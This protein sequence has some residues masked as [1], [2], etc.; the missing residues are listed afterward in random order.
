[1]GDDALKWLV[2]YM[3][4]D[5]PNGENDPCAVDC[6]RLILYATR[7]KQARTAR[8]LDA[9]RHPIRDAVGPDGIVKTANVHVGALDACGTPC[10]TLDRLAKEAHVNLAVD[11][12]GLLPQE[13]AAINPHRLLNVR[14]GP[15]S[16]RGAVNRLFQSAGGNCEFTYAEIDNV[17]LATQPEAARIR[18]IRSYDV[19]D[20]VTDFIAYEQSH[21]IRSKGIAPRNPADYADQSMSELRDLV[22]CSVTPKTWFN[23]GGS[24]GMAVPGN[25]LLFVVGDADQQWQVSRALAAFRLV[26]RSGPVGRPAAPRCLQ[27]DQDVFEK[28]VSVVPEL[29]LDDVPIE[30][31]LDMLGRIA[32]LSVEVDPSLQDVVRQPLRRITLRRQNIPFHVALQG[33]LQ[34]ASAGTPLVYGIR[35]GVILVTASGHQE[36]LTRGYRVRDL[37]ERWI[38]GHPF[39]KSVPDY[40]GHDMRQLGASFSPENTIDEPTELL[41]QILQKGVDELSWKIAGGGKISEI[42]GILIITQSPENHIKIEA[43]LDALRHNEAGEAS[44]L[45][46]RA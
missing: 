22:E 38:R 14:H 15:M 42:A 7:E 31:A 3:L 28:L 20:L 9:L 26:E 37:V 41:K 11:W 32:G 35:D 8:A 45:F 19:H 21:Q 44:D 34:Q 36:G 43:L 39:G 29:S 30:T 40:F 24:F 27:P 33:V 25:G 16:L 1:M 18:L 46:S 12:S 13:Q 4:R 2:V 10:D 17:L 5:G 6:G 23:E